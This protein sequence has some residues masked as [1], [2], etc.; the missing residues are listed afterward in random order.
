MV[1]RLTKT[2]KKVLIGLAK[3]PSLNDS[4]IADKLG[5]QTSSFSKIKQQIESL[6]IIDHINAIDPKK[7][8]PAQVIALSLVRCT[9]SRKNIELR[10]KKIN[11]LYKKYPQVFFKLHTPS[12]WI[13]LSFFK[14]FKEAEEYRLG[15]LDEL[16]GLI[17]GNLIWH[18]APVSHLK[19]KQDWGKTV[20]YLFSD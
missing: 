2:E 19:M 12:H 4:E 5:M 11:G 3:N 1:K 14:S 20:E 7:I 8:L 16:E 17:A 13:T 15:I 18:T 6:S 9:L 10:D